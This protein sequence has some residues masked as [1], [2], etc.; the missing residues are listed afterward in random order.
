MSVKIKPTS[1]IISRLGIEPRGRV[2]Q[3]FTKRCADYMDKYIPLCEGRLAYDNRV[4][5]ADRI[6]YDSPYAH[7]MYEGKVMGPSYP[8]KKNGII[9]RWASP[10]NKPKHYT[11]KDIDYSKSKARGHPYAGPQWD[12]RMWSAEKDDIVKEVQEL[13]NRGGH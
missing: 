7:Y 9:I 5:E 1:V 11:G 12:K 2:H 4:I 6:I 8:I 10:K 13:I 3:Y